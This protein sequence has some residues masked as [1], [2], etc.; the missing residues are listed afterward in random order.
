MRVSNQGA[1]DSRKFTERSRA[2]ILISLGI[3]ARSHQGRAVDPR[4]GDELSV[5]LTGHHLHVAD[6]PAQAVSRAL[7]VDE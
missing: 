5:L 1:S 7:D 4:L 6:E 2:T 3:Q